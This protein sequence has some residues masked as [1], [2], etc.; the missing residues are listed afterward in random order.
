MTANKQDSDDT[1]CLLCQ[2]LPR[3]R[4]TAITFQILTTSIKFV[5][6]ANADDV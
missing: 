3:I 5:T 1:A 4:T 6:E 2:L